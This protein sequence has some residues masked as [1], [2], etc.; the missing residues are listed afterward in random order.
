MR[1]DQRA[2][3]IL[4]ISGAAGGGEAGKEDASPKECR[5]APLLPLPRCPAAPLPRCPA[6]PLPR[7]PTSPLPYFP[8]SPLPRFPAF[9][10]PRSAD[11]ANSA[12]VVPSRGNT[13]APTFTRS[14]TISPM[15]VL[16]GC[17][18]STR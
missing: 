18:A 5:R 2:F 17:S 8:A 10:T 3:C 16:A 1:F 7:C 4:L 11:W 15:L 12:A 13:A 14:G 9:L 6:A